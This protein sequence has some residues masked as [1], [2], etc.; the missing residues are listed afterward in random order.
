[1]RFEN[2]V[3]HLKSSVSGAD[4]ADHGTGL[5]RS[6][7]VSLGVAGK[8]GLQQK[9]LVPNACPHVVPAALSWL[10]AQVLCG[11]PGY[12]EAMNSAL[13]TRVAD[14][15]ETSPTSTPPPPRLPRAHRNSTSLDR[16]L[17]RRSCGGGAARSHPRLSL[18]GGGFAGTRHQVCDSDVGILGRLD[19]ERHRH[20][21][22][23]NRA[24][25]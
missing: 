12:R 3:Q 5:P 15:S 21:P 25:R 11:F 10:L 17:A 22:R 13:F 9:R 24:R 6:S 7:A 18:G 2:N 4:D 20:S 14:Y 19:A 16:H 23:A 8:T 1:M